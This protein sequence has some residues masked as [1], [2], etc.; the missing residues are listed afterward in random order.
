MW[1]EAVVAKFEI[2][3]ISEFVWTDLKN[4]G[5]SIAIDDL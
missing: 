4:H 3:F 1:K 5:T 2:R